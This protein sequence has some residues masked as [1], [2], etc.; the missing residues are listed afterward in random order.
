MAND[1]PTAVGGL[2]SFGDPT[3]LNFYDSNPDSLSSYQKTLEDQI[4]SL[5]DRYANPNWFK[6]AAGFL[7]PQLGGFGASLGSA[8]DAIGENVEQQR[9]SEVPIAQMRSQLAMVKNQQDQQ[10]YVNRLVKNNKGPVT[11]QLVQDA[12]AHS[13]DSPATKSLQATLQT[14]QTQ[15]D[16]DLKAIAALNANHEP[17]PPELIARVKTGVG[18]V[19]GSSDTNPVPAPFKN[20]SVAS[21]DSSSSP[22]ASG[23]DQSNPTFKFS[24]T[25]ARPDVTGA[26]PNDVEYIRQQA[27]KQADVYEE[28]HKAEMASLQYL[29]RPTQYQQAMS[30]TQNALTLAQQ[31]PD[32]TK[33]VFDVVR[34]AGQLAAAGNAG[35][36]IHVGPYGASINVPTEAWVNAGISDDKLP[37]TNVSARDI[38]DRM[39]QYISS[40]AYY[41]MVARGI[42]PS[43]AGAEKMTLAMLQEP[44]M[45]NT[46]A[47]AM[48]A[49]ADNL[50]TF[51]MAKDLVS[52][53]TKERAKV[54]P[55]SLTPMHDIFTQS[56]ALRILQRKY[57]IINQNNLENFG[58]PIVPRQ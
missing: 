7:K 1:A 24:P 18:I 56:D 4:Q 3:K 12:V 10:G 11:P 16:L 47:S 23:P 13:P 50:N 33:K 31:Y 17:I 53:Y 2:S 46:Y 29:T 58:K 6:V 37:G 52:T 34:Q 27:T 35:F 36:G 49:L 43:T 41:G 19:P 21:T 30:N 39:K 54:H 22:K 5:H 26:N 42:D 38:A 45:N 48:N 9:A 28:P 44:L 51:R 25:V 15:L 8:A 55:H 14:G 32:I 57:E 20:P 40:S